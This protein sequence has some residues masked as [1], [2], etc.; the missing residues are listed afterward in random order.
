LDLLRVRAWAYVKA[1]TWALAMA[2]PWVLK[3]AKPRA[4]QKALA[5][6]W[7]QERA[8]A[9]GK[10]WGPSTVQEKVHPWAPSLGGPSRG[11]ARALQ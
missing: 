3:W 2:R 5:F 8:L 7:V 4:Q 11:K 1:S 10:E 6:E 9:R